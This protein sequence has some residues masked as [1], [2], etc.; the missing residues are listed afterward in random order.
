MEKANKFSEWGNSVTHGAVPETEEYNISSMVYRCVNTY[1]FVIMCLSAGTCFCIAM[2]YYSYVIFC[3]P[4][5]VFD[6]LHVCKPDKTHDKHMS[7][8]QVL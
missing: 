1:M 4:A 5:C 8:F 2:G 6:C 3:L 7:L